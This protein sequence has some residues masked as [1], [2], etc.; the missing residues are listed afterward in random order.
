MQW[1]MD[2][3]ATIIITTVLLVAVAAVIRYLINQKKRGKLSCGCGCAN[4]AMSGTCHANKNDCE[5]TPMR[6]IRSD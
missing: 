5:K 6:C 4:C 1:I 3:L 2:N